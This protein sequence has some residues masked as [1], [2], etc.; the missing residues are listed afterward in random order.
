[1]AAP[2]WTLIG[3]DAAVAPRNN[4]VIT[5][6]LRGATLELGAPLRP[7]SAA[8]LVE[9]LKRAVHSDTE[10][11]VLLCLDAPI[12]WPLALGR[13]LVGHRAGAPVKVPADRL[14]RRATDHDIRT[15]LGK[16][17]LDIGADRIARTSRTALETLDRLSSALGTQ[18][19]P[20]VGLAPMERS[21]PTARAETLQ[22]ISPSGLLGAE[23][24]APILPAG[25]IPLIESYPAGWFASE[26]LNTR[27]YRPPA[28]GKRRA[29][30]LGSVLELLKRRGV[31]PR[32]VEADAAARLAERADDLDA[33]VCTLNGLDLLEGLIEPP[34]P[35]LQ[36]RVAVEGWIWTKSRG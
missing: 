22:R 3:W 19:E 26:S 32:F 29:E 31:E 34:P 21:G 4:A 25:R 11:A 33:L 17:P 23:S 16:T 5:V 2:T 8:E 24:D 14:F 30:L 15:R 36:P 27:G 20:V 35:A 13:A 7:G 12:G 10:G 9:A 18:I 28:A 6:R 1:M